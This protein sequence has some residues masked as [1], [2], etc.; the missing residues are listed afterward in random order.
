MKRV[1]ALRQTGADLSNQAADAAYEA[2]RSRRDDVGEIARHTGIKSKN[3]QK[4]KDH[5]F[6]NVHL[7][8]LYVEFGIIPEFGR[9]QSDK[10]IAAAWQ[11]LIDGQYTDADFQLLRHEAAEAWYMRRHGPSYTAGH[12]AAQRRFPAPNLEED[13]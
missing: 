10:S 3:I 6:H 11:R 4:V 5:L 8:D 9:F 12:R 2:I 1:E 13:E 7:L